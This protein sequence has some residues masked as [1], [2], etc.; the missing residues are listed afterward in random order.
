M[1][2][3]LIRLGSTLVVALPI[4]ITIS[5]SS[6]DFL[7]EYSVLSYMNQLLISKTK[8][9]VLENNML[10]DAQAT[11]LCE[12]VYKERNLKSASDKTVFWITLQG[13]KTM[14]FNASTSDME[15]IKIE[16]LKTIFIKTN[17]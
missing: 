3:T 4:F 8:R 15:E 16:L 12:E 1:K 13:Y 17:D 2:K 5:C 10:S 7:G 11:S 6:T 14:K 9:I